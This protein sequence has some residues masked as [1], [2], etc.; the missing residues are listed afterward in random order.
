MKQL[1]QPSNWEMPV[2]TP[3]SQRL[4]RCCYPTLELTS[5]V[6]ARS[7]GRER[8]A[9]GSLP[10]G[11]ARPHQGP[12]SSQD[13]LGIR[14]LDPAVRDAGRSPTYRFET[15][16]PWTCSRCIRSCSRNESRRSRQVRC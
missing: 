14:R 13:L 16:D 6:H 10:Q 7:A 1:V 15:S 11:L 2:K 5:V 8:P 12:R 3:G 4:L 9:H